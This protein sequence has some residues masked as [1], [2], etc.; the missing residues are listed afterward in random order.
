[1]ND[2]CSHGVTWDEE[3]REC[4]IISITD[5]L[6]RWEPRVAALRTKLEELQNDAKPERS[7]IYDRR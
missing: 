2:K 7:E 4:E 6:K 3:C 5:T 1:M